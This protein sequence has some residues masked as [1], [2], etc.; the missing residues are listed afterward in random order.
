M[1]YSKKKVE[2]VTLEYWD[3]NNPYHHHKTEEI[4]NSCIQKSGKKRT[5][6]YFLKI[7]ERNDWIMD[8][9]MK[10]ATKAELARQFDLSATRIHSII[11]KI[12]RDQR[13]R[14]QRR[15]AIL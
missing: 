7:S 14:N 5:A 15:S 3:C 1:K 9:Y 2:I 6:A 10:G 8:S 11:S 4:A 12:E 13:K